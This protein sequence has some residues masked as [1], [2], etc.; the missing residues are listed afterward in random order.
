MEVT[1]LENRRA[2]AAREINVMPRT[3]CKL[4]KGMRHPQNLKADAGLSCEGGLRAHP[5]AS[6][7]SEDFDCI[8]DELGAFVIEVLQFV[9]RGFH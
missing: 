7:G 1:S 6:V 5:I 3:L 4:R 9:S 8:H 2:R